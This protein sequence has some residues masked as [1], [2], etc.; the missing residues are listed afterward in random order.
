[1][2]GAHERRG[3]R[4]DRKD[5]LF[6]LA[7]VVGAAV[8][9]WVL[10]RIDRQSA[11]VD[12]LA[13]ALATE[14][15]QAQDAG[16]TPAAPPPAE[17][18]DDPKVIVGERGEVGPRGP[19]GV[20]G[21]TG[22]MGPPGLMGPSGSPGVD[23][24]DGI[25]GQDGAPGEPGQDGQDG[26]DGVDGQDGRPPASWTWTDP[27]GAEYRCVRDAESPDTAPTYTCERPGGPGG[28]LG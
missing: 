20:P 28:L 17:I 27:Q 23:G 16:L 13:T 3:L 8:L 4:L 18:L 25:D 12:A 26:R 5:W 10:F 7:L 9:G 15:R 24:R 1:V 6:V 19:Q 22:N 14:Q 11:Q 2:T 21:P